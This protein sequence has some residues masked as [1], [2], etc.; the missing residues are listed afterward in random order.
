MRKFI[1]IITFII[2]ITAILPAVR[3]QVAAAILKFDK[4]EF[5]V[6]TGDTFNAAVVVDPGTE[7]ILG[8]DAYILYDATLLEAVSVSNGTYFD[9]VVNSLTTAGK[10]YI[11]GL[12]DDPGT[13]KT[14]VGTIATV[15]FKALKSGTGTL[16]YDCRPGA[17][18]A[19]KI[20]KNDIDATNIIDC[21]GNGT[22]SV[23]VAGA[24]STDSGTGTSTPTPTTAGGSSGG[25]GDTTTPSV[26]PKTGTFDNILKYSLPGLMLV[27]L[28]GV[29][30]LFL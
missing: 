21:A 15:T 5:S 11:A 14:G 12:V 2:L 19:S 25:T 13:S 1:T 27:L 6:N 29:I 10:A 8:S 4:T 3:G 24:G 23:T 18:D 22:A 26:L 17:S 30:K 16:S 7:N 9:S 28:G 20:V